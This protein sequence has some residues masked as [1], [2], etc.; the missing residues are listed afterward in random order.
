MY[1]RNLSD[2]N[3]FYKIKHRKAPKVQRGTKEKW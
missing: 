2:K 3:H 1:S